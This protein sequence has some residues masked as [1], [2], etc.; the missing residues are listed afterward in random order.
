MCFSTLFGHLY[1]LNIWLNKR[2]STHNCV[3][4]AFIGQNPPQK[5]NGA[6]KRKRTEIVQKCEV[7]GPNC[8]S[9]ESWRTLDAN[10]E[11]HNQNKSQNLRTKTYKIK[12]E[13]FDEQ[14]P[15]DLSCKKG[16]EVSGA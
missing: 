16:K 3:I 13:G 1:K 7:G 15:K 12:V 8:I 11:G 9:S 2:I 6:K 10:F 14:L 4:V 5:E